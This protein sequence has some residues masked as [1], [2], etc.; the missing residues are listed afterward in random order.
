ML[1]RFLIRVESLV[2]SRRNYGRACGLCTTG[3]GRGGDRSRK[4]GDALARGSA[5]MER[6]FTEWG[7]Y[8]RPRVEDIDS[9]SWRSPIE[10]PNR[11]TKKRGQ[12]QYDYH[13]CGIGKRSVDIYVA[14]RGMRKALADRKEA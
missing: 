14:P 2:V 4:G 10:Y 7:I 8:E 3:Q 9:G 11:T 1:P 13:Q 12:H 6:H 5:I